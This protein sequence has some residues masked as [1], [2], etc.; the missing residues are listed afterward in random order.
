MKPQEKKCSNCFKV[1][2]VTEFYRKLNDYQSRCKAC[3]SEVVC[4]YAKRLREK[5]RDLLLFKAGTKIAM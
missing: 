5:K 2:P 4:A 3:N 1:K